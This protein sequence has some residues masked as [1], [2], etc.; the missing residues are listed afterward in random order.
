MQHCDVAIVG[1]GFA[2][3]IAAA[4]LGRKGISTVL[5]DPNPVYPDDF[6]CEKLDGFQVSILEKTGLADLILPATTHDREVWLARFGCLMDCRPSDQHGIFYNDL[7]NTVRA[8]IPPQVRRAVARAVDLATSDD[9]QSV[10]LSTGETLSARLIVLATGLS[11]GLRDRLGIRRTVTSPCH[12]ITA[13]FN[14]VPVGRPAFPFRALT[15]HPERARDGISYLTV[16]PIGDLL[17]ANLMTYRTMDDPWLR[18]LRHATVPALE[19]VM[20][21]LRRMIGDFGVEGPVRI[22]PTDLYITSGHRQAGIVLVG[23]AFASPCPASGTGCGKVLTDVE[24]LCNIH[25]PQWLAS[26][27]MGIDK[28]AAFYDDPVKV[29]NDRR[30][31]A[32]AYHLREASINRGPRWCAE[33]VGRFVLRSGIGRLRQSRA[34]LS[35]LTRTARRH[36]R[37]SLP[38]D[39]PAS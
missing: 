4:M 36:E 22:R 39:R 6:R 18:Q 27:A 25:I 20:P 34:R 23:D 12:S 38:D 11:V 29:E 7:V 35:A 15:Y 9:R 17:R 26:D 21:S 24:R 19:A 30:S 37:A 28:I 2:G 10:T 13:G 14:L 31:T 8:I 32:K 16:F 3:S 5:V 1:G 33:R